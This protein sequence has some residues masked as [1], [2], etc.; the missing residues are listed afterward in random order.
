[1]KTLNI[2]AALLFSIFA[3]NFS[4]AQ[5]A[6]ENETIKVSGNC[7]MCKNKIE[8]AAK[9]GRAE[10]A[11]WNEK[12]KILND[13]Y[14]NTSSTNSEKIQKSIAAAGYDTQNFKADDKAYNKL[15]SCCKYN[16]TTSMSTK[17]NSKMA[18]KNMEAC[19]DKA[20]YKNGKCDANSCKEI[21]DCKATCC[22]KS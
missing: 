3:I 21:A 6:V 7:G 2:Y 5:T 14:N 20:C 11:N 22:S 12:T 15:M 13:S 10:T 19:K 9:V 8:K 4:F 18:C 16:R 17:G 1:M